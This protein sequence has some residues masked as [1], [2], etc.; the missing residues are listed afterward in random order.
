[1]AGISSRHVLVLCCMSGQGHIRSDDACLTLKYVNDSLMSILWPDCNTRLNVM[2]KD[3]ISI[4][5]MCLGLMMPSQCGVFHWAVH[6]GKEDKEEH[7]AMANKSARCGPIMHRRIPF[8][9][10]CCHGRQDRASFPCF[11]YSEE[12]ASYVLPTCWG[13][14]E[15]SR[16]D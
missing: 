16:P 1:M 9:W 3:A 15:V 7:R 2:P 13:Q 8:K 4:K 12:C 14:S 10:A 11:P 5:A 6:N